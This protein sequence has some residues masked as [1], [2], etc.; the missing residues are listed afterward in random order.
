MRATR[1]VDDGTKSQLV[2]IIRLWTALTDHRP[3]GMSIE[4]MVIT[5]DP[6]RGSQRTTYRDI[7]ALRDAG[8]RIEAVQQPDG[9]SVRYHL[10]GPI[11]ANPK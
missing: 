10:I 3:N 4:Q 6:R 9:V 8:I 1:R 5:V 2:R 7:S 11:I